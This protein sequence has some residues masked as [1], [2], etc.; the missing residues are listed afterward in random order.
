MIHIP[1]G[2]ANSLACGNSITVMGTFLLPSGAGR[3]LSVNNEVNM[4]P[5]DEKTALNFTLNKLNK[6]SS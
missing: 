1:F 5:E 6:I 2:H 4:V 3:W